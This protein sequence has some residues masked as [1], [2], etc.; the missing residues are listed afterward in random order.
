METDYT[1]VVVTGHAHGAF[2]YLQGFLEGRGVDPSRV[3]EAEREGFACE[4]LREQIRDLLGPAHAT[5][6]LLVPAD[7]LAITREAIDQGAERGEAMA[8]KDA[9]PLAG[10]RFSYSFTAFS[11]PDGERLQALF[12]RLEDGLALDLESGVE[13]SIEPDAGGAEAYA[14]LHE[15]EARGKGAV[16]GEVAAVIRFYRRLK[17]EELIRL[18]P[19]ELVG[20]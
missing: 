6:H 7:L 18:K 1:E 9:R 17:Q 10:A 19:L 16:A 14:P 5:L 12:A 20:R 13:V 11:R 15:Y 8:L 3:F 2:S 4:P